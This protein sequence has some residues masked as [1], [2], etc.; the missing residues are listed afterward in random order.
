MTALAIEEHGTRV[1]YRTCTA[2]E[3]GG[4]CK[5]C[6]AANAVATAES[7]RSPRSIVPAGKVRTHLAELQA[8]G[9]SIGQIAR[10]AKVGKS[11]VGD[12]AIGATTRCTV[13]TKRRLLGLLPP[14]RPVSYISVIPDE[15]VEPEPVYDDPLAALV[16]HLESA[17]DLAWKA[18]GDCRRLS[19]SVQRRQEWFF[20]ERGESTKPALAIC[21]RCPV[22]ADCL[23]FALQTQAEGVWGR[24]AGSHRRKIVHH[25][26]TVAELAAAGM[27]NDSELSI[28]DAIE[29]VVASR[30]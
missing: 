27:A 28:T 2:G 23:A 5:V 24:S 4:P 22:W 16:L 25:G 9:L 26:I 8:G 15:E 3:G 12:L 19:I 7:R 6:R 20:P 30:G 1:A 10:Q 18:D 17:A 14:P 29:R 13:E 21:A 11:T